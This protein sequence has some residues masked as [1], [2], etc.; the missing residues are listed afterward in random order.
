MIGLTYREGG[1]GERPRPGSC[2]L[3]RVSVWKGLKDGEHLLQLEEGLFS[4]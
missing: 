4:W 3:V 1:P 2:G